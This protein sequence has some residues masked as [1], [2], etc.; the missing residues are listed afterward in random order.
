MV[1][2]RRTALLSPFPYRRC[3]IPRLSGGE[4]VVLIAVPVDEGASTTEEA[5]LAERELGQIYWLYLTCRVLVMLDDDY[6]TRFWTCIE[7][8]SA[9][10]P[11][12]RSRRTATGERCDV[13][14]LDCATEADQAMLLASWK[15]LSPASAY[16]KLQA[17]E[18]H[19][20]NRRDKDLLVYEL[21]FHSW[22]GDQISRG[23]DGGQVLPVSR[24]QGA[25]HA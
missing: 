3:Q 2:P 1:N 16:E 4:Y 14:L 22:G 12:V 20:T 6:A 19:I 7:L 15:G 10:R 9:L 11:Q 23:L 25:P 21:L 5:T 24:Y 17:D 8:W 18:V 13:A